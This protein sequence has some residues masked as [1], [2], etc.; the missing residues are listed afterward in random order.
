MKSPIIL[1]FPG[2]GSLRGWAYFWGWYVSGFDPEQHCQKCLLGWR[3]E[4]VKNYMKVGRSLV[5]DE[6]PAFD[7]FYVC[8]G[9]VGWNYSKNFHL[10]LRPRDG[11]ETK[12]K[13]HTGQE[14]IALN[15]E[16]IE[17]P[18]LPGGFNGKGPKFTTCRNYQFA[19]HAYQF[20]L[21]GVERSPNEEGIFGIRPE[22]DPRMQEMRRRQISQCPQKRLF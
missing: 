11:W 3:S 2:N 15:A 21:D 16:Y 8:G 12:A 22:L 7:F 4:L 18:A 5:L 13:C 1:Q 19:V 10:A 17:I 20:G 6:R 14:V 9:D